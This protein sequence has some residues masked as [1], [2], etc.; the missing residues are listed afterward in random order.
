MKAS[1]LAIAALLV[2]VPGA[3]VA[4]PGDLVPVVKAPTEI[5][6]RWD[7]D[8][9]RTL[10]PLLE[11]EVRGTYAYTR[12]DLRN[13]HETI[14]NVVR[15]FDS[16][17][18]GAIEGQD[19]PVEEAGA[20]VHSWRRGASPMTAVGVYVVTERA[21]LLRAPAVILENVTSTSELTIAAQ[22]LVLDEGPDML[23]HALP[24][25]LEYAIP[26][27]SNDFGTWPV[28]ERDV[29]TF[30][31]YPRIYAW[32]FRKAT[33]AGDL[34]SGA[35][36][37]R[38]GSWDGGF[39]ATEPFHGVKSIEV[40]HAV[41]LAGAT[42]RLAGAYV[43][44]ELTKVPGDPHRT[45]QRVTVG[46]ATEASG[47][48]PVATVDPTATNRIP[49]TTVRFED[50]RSGPHRFG[51]AEDQ[52]TGI[53]V[54]TEASGAWVPLLGTWTETQHTLS[55]DGNDIE[56]TRLTSI[57]PYALGEYAPALGVRYHGD[58]ST[59]LMWA[60]RFVNAGTLGGTTM[61]DWEIDVGT[62]AAGAFQPVL[63]LTY[64]DDFA[65]AHHPFQT[66][67]TAGVHTPKGY[68]AVAVFTYDGEQ[69]LVPWVAAWVGGNRETA[70]EWTMA[71]GT[72]GPSGYLPLVGARYTPSA[73]GAE[74][75]YQ[76]HV[77]AGVFLADYDA[78]VPV[79]AATYDGDA[80]VVPWAAR[81][82]LGGAFGARAGEWDLEAGTYSPAVATPDPVGVAFAETYRPVVEARSRDAVAESDAARQQTVT[83]GARVGDAFV[84]IAAATFEGENPLAQSFGSAAVTNDDSRF[85]MTAGVHTPSAYVPLVALVSD[86]DAVTVIAL[87]PP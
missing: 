36:L 16:D 82:G 74:R 87:P 15:T 13:S 49:V 65:E 45:T 47:R 56:Q 76:D 83:V 27:G 5:F 66:M 37:E 35:Y 69:P 31:D 26:E 72:R 34:W 50:E 11:D 75:T 24:F 42:T 70:R 81:F 63:G 32:T 18:A 59:T 48:T 79:L 21:G 80:G 68:R 58:R 60:T 41:R 71:S 12:V 10:V 46:A 52:R 61:G 4:D 7:P 3:T 14:A 64:A 2:V 78:F 23:V 40:G 20:Y 73:P 43:E 67:I 39:G 25:L 33:V 17:V 8:G 1:V 84:P 55:A 9:G 85:Y 6:V 44:T 38:L 53:V 29:D 86:R 28:G 54:G 19:E 30:R 62:F 22:R 51:Y 77:T 57:G